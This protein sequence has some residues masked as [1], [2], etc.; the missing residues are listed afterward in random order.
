VRKEILERTDGCLG[1]HGCVLADHIFFIFRHGEFCV[2]DDGHWL[3]VTKTSGVSVE[4][5][6]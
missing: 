3:V 6:P 4:L 1:G 2:S 5:Q